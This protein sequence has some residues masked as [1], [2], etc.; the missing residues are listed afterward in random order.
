MRH[1]S[2]STGGD[3]REPGLGLVDRIPP[4]LRFGGLAYEI[5]GVPGTRPPLPRAPRNKKMRRPRLGPWWMHLRLR[6][7][8]P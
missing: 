7:I 6:T 3:S 8:G 1:E 2:R 5:G 4:E